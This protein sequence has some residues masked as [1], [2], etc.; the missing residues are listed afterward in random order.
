MVV[1]SDYTSG[2]IS[3]AN[4]STTVTGTGT[5]F[6]VAKFREGDTLQIQ[7]LTAVIA[8][9][10][11]NTQLTLTEPWTGTTLT[12]APYRARYLSDGARVTAQT[13][14]LIELLGNGNLQALAGL[15]GAAN[16]LP[17]FT[18]AGTMGLVDKGDVGI[19]DPNGSLAELAALTLAARQILQTDV[20]GA[21]K[22][23]ALA[24][25]KALVTDANGDIAP[26]DLGTLGR[27][28]LALASGT[29]AQ[30]IR[31]DGTL[32]V[33]N[34]ASVGLG[35]VDNTSDASKPIST[36]QQT[37]LNAKANLSGATFTGDVNVSSGIVASKS[38]RGSGSVG[39]YINGG[40]L[41]SGFNEGLGL[42]NIYH[43]EL[44]GTSNQL[45]IDVS[46]GNAVRAYFNFYQDGDFIAPGAIKGASKQFEIDHTVDPD[47]YD[48]RH[49]ATEAPE[50]LVEYRGIAKLVN[51]RATVNVEEHYGVM[52]DTFK[53]LWADAHV[54]ALQNQDGFARVRPSP[55][56]GAS[57][58]I[59]SEDETCS[60]NVTWLVMAR[61][62]DPYVRW[63]GCLSTDDE[64]RLIIEFE[65]PE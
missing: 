47:N 59:I 20:N 51:G 49:C 33:L 28:L 31:A 27:A 5:L 6:D 3:L 46:D 53:N 43:Q 35:N 34:A 12:D 24:A 55:V 9:V 40:I 25:N 10:D 16:Q 38:N 48:L 56:D 23:V 21:L 41:R 18:G 63:S 15:T 37:A 57:F 61:R 1:L 54:H 58:E 64:G 13:T 36:A 8:R 4:G 19:Q 50:M 14:T 42:T 39:D 60:D 62:N 65:K 32:Q 17:I 26:I 22:A 52:P 45:V 11:S 7:N 29:S 44:V 30:Y 2:T